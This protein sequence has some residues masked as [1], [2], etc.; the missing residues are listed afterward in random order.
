MLAVD[1]DDETEGKEVFQSPGAPWRSLQ[2]H[3][4]LAAFSAQRFVCRS[5]REGSSSS[6]NPLTA[7]GFERQLP[8]LN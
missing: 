7:P 3:W 5:P 2:S 1:G 6:P 8:F 4:W